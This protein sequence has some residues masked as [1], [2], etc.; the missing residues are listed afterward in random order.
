MARLM[1]SEDPSVR[2][3]V[4]TGVLG[5]DPGAADLKELRAEIRQ[6]PRVRALLEARDADGRLPWPPYRKW[7]GAHWVLAHL[8]D[9]GYP[10]GDKSIEPLV[11]QAASWS[12]GIQARVIAGRPRRCASQQGNTLLSLIRL[13]FFDERAHE[14]A[15]RLR[16]W[17]WPDGGW[18]CDKRPSASHSSFH[19]TLI[20]MR[21]LAAY[22]YRTRDAA[23]ATSARRAAELFLE[24]RLY[25]RRTTGA[26][27]EQRFTELHYPYYWQYTILHALVGMGE[28]ALL[29]D[30]RCADA[31]ELLE[32]KRLA[33]GSFPAER[34][35]YR[36]V[37]DPAAPGSGVSTVDWGTASTARRRR[38]N[39]LVTADALA[40]LR[41]AG[42]ALA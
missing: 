39:D 24:R 28:Q 2:Y 18:N 3:K 8:A 36:V 33:D 5:V 11:D 31:L 21:A 17:Q 20:P 15:R 6:S 1:Q 32:S 10:P 26:V 38:G 41:R 16:S 13:G 29:A 12:L 35:Y 25:R 19:E 34:R 22:A 7:I 40:V 9:L 23:A 30:P 42:R 27:I 14:L 37:R 4:R